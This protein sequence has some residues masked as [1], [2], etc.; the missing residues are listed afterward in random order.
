MFK[1]WCE[2]GIS[3]FFTQKRMA[4]EPEN[5]ED[6]L[7]DKDGEAGEVSS[8]FSQPPVLQRKQEIRKVKNVWCVARHVENR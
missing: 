5:I 3:S 7:V 2:W 1:L 6:S 4:V 8:I